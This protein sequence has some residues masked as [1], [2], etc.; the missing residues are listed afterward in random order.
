MDLNSNSDTID[1]YDTGVSMYNSN[2]TNLPEIGKS[3]QIKMNNGQ[4]RS[5]PALAY[6]TRVLRVHD[7][8]K[9][10]PNQAKLVAQGHKVDVIKSKSRSKAIW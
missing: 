2:S 1:S 7:S 10:E 9:N 8:L 3:V 4:V 5:P 6:A